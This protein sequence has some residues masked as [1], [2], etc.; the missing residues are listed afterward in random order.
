MPWL[1]ATT[2]PRKRRPRVAVVCVVGYSSSPAFRRNDEVNLGFA[3]GVVC[4]VGSTGMLAGHLETAYM[5]YVLCYTPLFP[6]SARDLGAVGIF[7]RLFKGS[8]H[9]VGSQNIGPILV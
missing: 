4:F 8:A 7:A 6:N 9:K 1:A 3:H 2:S 5:D